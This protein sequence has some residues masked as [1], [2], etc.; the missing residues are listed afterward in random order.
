MSP[1]VIARS[2][3][4]EAISIPLPVIPR[5]RSDRRISMGGVER[6]PRFAR[7]DM[8]QKAI[9]GYEDLIVWQRSMDLVDTVCR[10]AGKLP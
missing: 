9:V 10:L 5:E 7:N 3:S 6:L 2:M 4:D 8:R 1:T